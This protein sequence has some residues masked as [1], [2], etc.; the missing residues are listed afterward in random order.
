[1]CL[2]IHNPNTFVT[3]STANMKLQ[4]DGETATRNYKYITRVSLGL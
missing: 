2:N 3:L 4:D 1:M